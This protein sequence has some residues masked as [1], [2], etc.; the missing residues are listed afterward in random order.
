V[1]RAILAGGDDYELCF[2]ADPSGASQIE[3]LA[4]TLELA[5]TRIGRIVEGDAVTVR[6]ESGGILPIKEGGFDHFR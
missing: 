1:D 6:N 3:T 4:S 2:T 5:L